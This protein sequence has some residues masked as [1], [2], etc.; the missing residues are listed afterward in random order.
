M[1]TLLFYSNTLYLFD[2]FLITS[3]QDDLK[4]KKSH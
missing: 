4:K 3:I 1:Q 2:F